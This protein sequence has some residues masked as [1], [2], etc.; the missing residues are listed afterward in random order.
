M[1]HRIYYLLRGGDR[2]RTGVRG[3]AGPCLTTRPPRR[4]T[5]ARRRPDRRSVYAMPLSP[6][7]PGYQPPSWNVSWVRSEQERDRDEPTEHDDDRDHHGDPRGRHG[8]AF[9]DR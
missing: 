9:A 2:N 8:F 1:E 4:N 5:R 7:P 6:R 3:F